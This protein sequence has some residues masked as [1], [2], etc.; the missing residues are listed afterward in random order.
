MSPIPCLQWFNSA[1]LDLKPPGSF[2]TLGKGI[3]REPGMFGWD[4]GA[5]RKIS[6]T[7]DR[8]NMQ[9]R[10]R[11]FNIFN[12]PMFNNPPTDLRCQLRQDQGDARSRIPARLKAILLRASHA[13]F[14]WR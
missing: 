1:G 11:F 8:V 12:H 10:A 2:G 3:L 9:F 13:S 6:L 5:F 7:G 4:M 14:N